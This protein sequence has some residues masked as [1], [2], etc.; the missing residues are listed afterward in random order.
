MGKSLFLQHTNTEE[1]AVS[2]PIAA[3]RR[4]QADATLPHVVFVYKKAERKVLG[5]WLLSSCAMLQGDRVAYW[6]V[7]R[8]VLFAEPV[9]LQREDIS[10]LSTIVY[11]T[12]PKEYELR[13]KETAVGG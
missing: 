7:D 8:Q 13:S 11:F 10:W 6:R 3:P 1:G 12:G 5:A 9:Q 2:P 4:R